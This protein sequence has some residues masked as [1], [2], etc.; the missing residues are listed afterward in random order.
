MTNI[1]EIT[2]IKEMEGVNWEVGTT[3]SRN[4]AEEAFA[5]TEEYVADGVSYKGSISIDAS[6][7]T[8]EYFKASGWFLTREEFKAQFKKQKEATIEATAKERLDIL[9]NRINTKIAEYTAEY[10]RVTKELEDNKHDGEMIEWA[11]EA[12][13]VFYNLVDLLEKLK[14]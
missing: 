14:A 8:R 9:N 11:D 10:N 2:L 4:N 3:F 13:T 5:L 12:Q 6:V 7:V 1:K